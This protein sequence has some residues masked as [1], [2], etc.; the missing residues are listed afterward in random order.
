MEGMTD[1]QINDAL[2]RAERF[3]RLELPG[4]PMAMHMG[5]SQLVHDLN[6][7]VKQLRT[8]LQQPRWRS[9]EDAPRDGRELLLCWWSGLH[10]RWFY[11]V[12]VYSNFDVARRG[13]GF[14]HGGATHYKPLPIPPEPDQ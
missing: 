4:Q 10:G 2:D 5:T 9:V 8:E 1:K 12:G 13:E 6:K 11:E 3:A 14:C 7:A